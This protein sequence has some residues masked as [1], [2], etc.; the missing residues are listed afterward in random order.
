MMTYQK[1]YKYRAVWMGLAIIWIMF[2][3]AGIKFHFKITRNLMAVGYGGTDIFLFASGLGCAFSYRKNGVFEFIRRRF[4]RVY[5]AYLLFMLVWIPCYFLYDKMPVRSIIGNLLGIE[6]FTLSRY[7]FN[8][9]FPFLI[10]LYLITPVLVQIIEKCKRIPLF[11]VFLILLLSMSIPFF[12]F[13]NFIIMVTRIPVYAAG[14][15]FAL[16]FDRE[17]TISGKTMIVML[18]LS[19]AGAIC[20]QYFYSRYNQLLWN[21]G[22][23]WYPFL[24]ITPGLCFLISYL[25]N[26]LGK[27]R[28]VDLFVK[29]LSKVGGISLE[30]YFVHIFLLDIYRHNV[31]KPDTMGTLLTLLLSFPAALLLQKITALIKKAVR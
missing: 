18:V 1:A 16:R 19:A 6:Y 13:R 28:A 20:L 12:T 25:C 15:W 17:K 4:G 22:L 2:F 31:L 30:L 7:S 11:I 21:Y 3:H 9:Y 10:F 5:P 27:I 24:F 8:W 14:I 23:H 26:T 29:L